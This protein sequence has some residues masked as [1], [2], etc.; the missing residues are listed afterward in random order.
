MQSETQK[1]NAWRAGIILL[2]VLAHLLFLGKVPLYLEEPRRAMIALEMLLSGN[3]LLPTIFSEAYYF[4]PPLF[5]WLIVG[6]Y[7]IFGVSEWVPRGISVASLFGMAVLNYCWVRKYASEQLAWW[8]SVGFVLC[9][10]LLFYFSMFG[11]IDL[12]FSLLSF[13][14]IVSFHHFFRQG[15]TALAFSIPFL[16]A[17]LGFLTK[18]IPAISY[19]GIS[20]LVIAFLSKRWKALFGW[21]TFLAAGVFTLVGGS[22]FFLYWKAGHDIDQFLGATFKQAGTRVYDYETES[23]ALAF[24][25]RTCKHLLTFPFEFLLTAAPV[26]LFALLLLK[27]DWRNRMLADDWIRTVLVLL[28][29][30]LLL[31]WLSNG[32]RMRYVYALFPFVSVV[33]TAC[34]L[35]LI[36]DSARKLNWLNYAAIVLLCA[37]LAFDLVVLPIRAR[38]GDHVLARDTAIEISAIAE[39]RELHF[40]QFKNEGNF[41]FITAYYLQA[42]RMKQLRVDWDYDCSTYYLANRWDLA[43][44]DIEIFKEWRYRE[45]DNFVV[46]FRNC[47]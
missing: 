43:Q 2:G 23:S 41:S 18:G 20:M 6:G 19:L 46:R 17:G 15:K 27:R 24:L 3:Y 10:D 39:D 25:W 44:K 45:F 30:N 9:A 40:F 34:L 14:S 1:Q 37:R 21:Q 11:E 29:A 8:S 16:L 7:K 22:F 28:L 38:E 4:K 35:H 5:N 42:I 47:D 33:G 26:S 36:G 32:T 12:F 31:Y 13:A